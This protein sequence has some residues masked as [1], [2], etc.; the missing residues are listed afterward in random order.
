MSARR[1]RRE[2]REREAAGLPALAPT[3]RTPPLA[4][5]LLGLLA[6]AIL[7]LPL[8]RAPIEQG[9]ADDGYVSIV[10][11]AIQRNWLFPV[12]DAPDEADVDGR[13]ERARN[14]QIPAAFDAFIRA[15]FLAEDMTTLDPAIWRYD[16]RQLGIDPRA[17]LISSAFEGASGWRGSLLFAGGQVEQQILDERGEQVAALVPGRPGAARRVRSRLGRGRPGRGA[18]LRRQH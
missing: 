18:E 8:L 13:V 16:G 10:G 12:T 11:A 7:L 5:S 2:R 4:P 17:H 14:P 1:A 9:G 15:S 3:R 6:A